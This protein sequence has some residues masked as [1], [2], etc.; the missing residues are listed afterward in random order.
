[1]YSGLY[2]YKRSHLFGSGNLDMLRERIGRQPNVNSVF[3]STYRY[4]VFQRSVRVVTKR[5]IL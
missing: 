2:S 3:L 1:M 5:S 4:C